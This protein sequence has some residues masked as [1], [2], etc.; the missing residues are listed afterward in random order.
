MPKY[1]FAPNDGV[2]VF[3]DV[4]KAR[5]EVLIDIPCSGRRRQQSPSSKLR[6]NEPER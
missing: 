5:N 2:L 1:K 6:L 4:A 3:I